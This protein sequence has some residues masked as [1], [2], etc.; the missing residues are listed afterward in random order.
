MFY[1]Y[2]F[3]GVMS[4]FVPFSPISTDLEGKLPGRLLHPVLLG[5]LLSR[6]HQ[7]S[8][9]DL[10]C[11]CRFP[12]GLCGIWVESERVVRT[13][14]PSIGSKSASLRWKELNLPCEAPET[15]RASTPILL[16]LFAVDLAGLATEAK[17]SGLTSK[18]SSNS[19]SR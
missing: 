3:S 6:G 5:H 11:G 8:I 1:T 7:P 10:A 18:N 14:R 9:G 16:T 19:N 13:G 17:S 4:G 2:V 12:R 15:R